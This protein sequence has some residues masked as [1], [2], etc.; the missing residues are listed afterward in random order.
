[1]NNVPASRSDPR[2]S[3]KGQEDGL[4]TRDGRAALYLG[5]SGIVLADRT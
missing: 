2:E 3:T 4:R 1:M 5:E